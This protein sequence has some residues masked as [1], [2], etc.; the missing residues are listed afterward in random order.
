MYYVQKRMEIAGCHHLSL[1]YDSPC[2]RIHGH[3]WVVTV[4][5]RSSRLNADGM[6]VD[7]K[8]IKDKIHGYLDH[9]NLNELLPFNPTAENI[10]RW[11]VEQVPECYKASVQESEGNIATYCVD[12]DSDDRVNAATSESDDHTTFKVNE[13]FYS[14]QGEGYHTGTPAVFVRLSGCNMACDFCDTDH[15]GGEELTIAEIVERVA[16]YGAKHVVITGGESTLQ[17]TCS[18]VDAL[19]A[20]GLYVQIETNGSIPITPDLLRAIDWITVSPKE[21][22]LPAIQRIDELKVVYDMYRTGWV[23]A[24]ERY[25]EL[26]QHLFLQPCDRA[27]EQWRAA[28]LRHCIDYILSHPCWRLSL[29][30]HKLLNIR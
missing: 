18:L 19:H 30:T 10:A 9:G 22:Q 13:I 12:D 23:D 29:Q 28:N 25:A 7:F 16:P 26:S 4:Y 14:L 27:D 6:V 21:G 3:N 11:V 8:H 15:H 20:H 17:L 1:S 24:L 2:S 5:C